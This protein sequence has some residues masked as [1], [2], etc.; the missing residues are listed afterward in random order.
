MD[1]KRQRIIE[2][3]EKSFSMFGYKATTVEQ[4]AKIA[5]VGKGSI[6]LYFQTKEDILKAVVDS[7]IQKMACKVEEAAEKE[8]SLKERLYKVIQVCLAYRKEHKML[9]KLTEEVKQIGTTQA[10][11]AI[12]QFEDQAIDFLQ[13]RLRKAQELGIFRTKYLEESAFIIFHLYRSLVF[14]WERKHPPLSEDEIFEMVKY[15]ALNSLAVDVRKDEEGTDE[16][17]AH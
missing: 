17:E 12:E 7:L 13:N 1:E 16:H 10:K 8:S 4:I 3:G 2:A 5:D 11:N 9:L 14:E 6:Y 15:F